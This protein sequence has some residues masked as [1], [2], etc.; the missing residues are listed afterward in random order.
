MVHGKG[1]PRAQS[2]GRRRAWLFFAALALTA[3]RAGAT[4]GAVQDTAGKPVEEL[5]RA[6]HYS[7]V[8]RVFP[9]E[10]RLEARARIVVENGAERPVREVPFLLYR[11]F[12]VGRVT[13]GDGSPLPFVADVVRDADEANLQVNL[14]TVALAEP[15][16]PGRSTEIAVDFAGSIHGY[17]EVW[18][19]VRDTIG[20]DYTLL[21]E[22]TF[23]YPILSRADAASRYLDRRFSYDLEVSVPEGY[24]VATGGRGTGV[25]NEGER[26]V[27]VYES[28]VPVWR[29]DVAIARF[30][31]RRDDTGALS[32]YVLPGHEVGAERVLGA[33][34]DAVE[35]FTRVFG[36][37]GELHGLTAI[38]IPGGW[39]SQAGDL[40]FLQT[41]AAFVDPDRIGEV[42]H[43]VAHN[44][45]AKPRPEVQRARY[46]DE[47]FASYFEALALRALRGDEAWRADLEKSRERFAEWAGRDPVFFET[48][49]AAYAENDLGQ[50][51][52]TKG[53]WSLYVLHRLVG[54]EDFGE[55]VRRLLAASAESAIGFD[56]FERIAAEVSGRDLGRYFAEW[57][58][59][60]E[61]SRLL[62]DNVPID[63]IV[64]RYR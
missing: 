14:V 46:F 52:Y 48:P 40:Y 47:A 61:S 41:A 56:D 9:S 8:Y 2:R 50:L 19:Y 27:H 62:V 31:V 5:P 29:L 18:A 37:A 51:S 58:H 20:E 11:L 22:D 35:L 30:S 59:G 39:G 23:A 64:S 24:V 49:I 63:E 33:M 55:I 7:L 42:Y 54:D 3:A 12:D 43:E 45:N 32:V 25:R 10:G 26:V 15:L 34:R 1:A 57:L 6:T 4:G 44:W 53:A 38:E 17:R 28:K 13:A 36:P 21:R 16:A 60:A